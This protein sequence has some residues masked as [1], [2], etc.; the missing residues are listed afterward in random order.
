MSSPVIKLAVDSDE[1]A[2]SAELGGAA[3]SVYSE[4]GEAEG[5][6]EFKGATSLQHCT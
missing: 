1:D 3:S 6:V 4:V 2:T 5:E